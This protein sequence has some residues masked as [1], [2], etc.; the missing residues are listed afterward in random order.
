MNNPH[1]L[2]Q[3]S[4]ERLI[5]VTEFSQKMYAFAACFNACKVLFRPST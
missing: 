3:D 2:F 5:P 4:K 1:Y